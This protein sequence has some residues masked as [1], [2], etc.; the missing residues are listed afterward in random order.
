MIIQINR[1]RSSAVLLP[2]SSGVLVV[3]VACAPEV[4]S[5]STSRFADVGRGLPAT[6]ESLGS[7]DSSSAG[8]VGWSSSTGGSV[9]GG[10]VGGGSVTGGSVVGALVV[11]GW[12]VV[13]WQPGSGKS[14]D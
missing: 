2:P 14:V 5:P 1:R 13:V 9:G 7:V 4:P 8:G 10:S 12:L 6:W 3:V 11:V